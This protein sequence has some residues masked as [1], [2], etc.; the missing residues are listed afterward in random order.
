[1]GQA[2]AGLSV[3][4]GRANMP[5]LE[6]VQKPEA[7]K[8]F[9][10]ESNDFDRPKRA[11]RNQ[12]AEHWGADVELARAA[13]DGSNVDTVSPTVLS[14]STCRPGG[15]LCTTLPNY[16]PSILP[17]FTFTRVVLGNLCARRFLSRLILQRAP[18]IL[19]LNYSNSPYA[20]FETYRHRC[21]SAPTNSLPLRCNLHSPPS[22]ESD[23]ARVRPRADIHTGLRCLLPSATSQRGI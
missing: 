18:H 12:L 8:A 11:W 23:L 3:R 21:Q 9:E 13:N 7:R 2:A 22:S 17:S 6:D 10:A 4:Q 1:M 16:F 15:Y 20:S 19:L 5:L 14:V